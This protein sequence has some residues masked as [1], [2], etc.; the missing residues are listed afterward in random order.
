[1]ATMVDTSVPSLGLA[2]PFIVASSPATQGYRAVLKSAQALPGAVVMRN[3]R[4]G[5]GGG[6]LVSPSAEDM[7][8]GRAATEIHA[9]GQTARDPF[10]SF[11]EY[12]ETVARLRREI[13]A[14]VRLWV[15]V[16]H[17]SD[18]VTGAVD[19]RE[20]WTTQAVRLQAAGADALELHFNTPGVVVAGDRIHDFER[21]VYSATQMVKAVARVPVVVKLPVE[22]C[23]PLRAIEAAMHGGASAVGPTARWKAFVF[24]LDWRRSTATPGGGYGG[25]QALPIICYTVAEA[26]QHGIDLPM[27]AGGG[28]FGWEAAAKLI[29]AGSQAVQLGSLACHLGP[30]AVRNV[31]SEFG[32]WLERSPYDSVSALCGDALQ[33]FRMPHEVAAER[34]RRLAAA[35]RAATVNA[36]L[37]TGCE[38][39]VDAC[40]FDAMR[41]ESGVAVKQSNCIGCG[42]CFQACPSG[43][44]SVDAGAIVAAPLATN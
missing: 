40:W 6:G 3:Y 22:S 27:F 10:A 5:A 14:A 21:L 34:V 29:M 25:T 28:V 1:M 9:L 26:R 37:C 30:G 35:Y 19:W 8:A 17:F 12:V 20:D 4:H 31:I 11:D 33:L 36:A 7:E 13:P 18:T 15:S 23:D 2:N 42:Y 24:D 32:A 39:C 43:A 41:L 38:R 16:G 44:L